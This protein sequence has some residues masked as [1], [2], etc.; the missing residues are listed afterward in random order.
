M[1]EMMRWKGEMTETVYDG[2]EI[3]ALF[4]CGRARVKVHEG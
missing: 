4:Y 3:V 2:V 1:A